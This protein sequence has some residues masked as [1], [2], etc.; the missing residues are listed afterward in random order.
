[1]AAAPTWSSGERYTSPTSPTSAS[2]NSERAKLP[3]PL[4]PES[5]DLRFA[6]GVFDRRRGRTIWVREDHTE[7][8]REAVNTIAGVDLDGDGEGGRVLVSGHDFY[9]APRPQPRR[10]SPRL[11]GLEPPEYALD[12]SD[13]GWAR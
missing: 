4:T 6:D 9:A 8:G 2:T 5:T 1:M 13:L 3:K 11:G 7:A 10:F 12:E